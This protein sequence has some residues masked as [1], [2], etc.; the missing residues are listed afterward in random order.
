MR[1]L[2]THT[3][4]IQ[5]AVRL[6]RVDLH[7]VDGEVNPA[8]LL[9]KH[10]LSRERLEAF[11]KLHGCEYIGGRAES[12]PQARGGASSK[13]TMASAS[14]DNYVVGTLSGHER[15]PIM[16]HN[17]L[18]QEALDREYPSLVAPED[19]QLDDIANDSDDKVFQAGMRE[20]EKI[21]QTMKTQGRRKETTQGRA[22]A[23]YYTTMRGITMCGCNHNC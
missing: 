8:E 15:Q 13:T 17:E 6:G 18:S 16:P 14:A 10:S 5:Q 12:A 21:R 22:H 3:L 1:H 11:V 19:D 7:K 23:R 20:V 9:T 4:W 2:D